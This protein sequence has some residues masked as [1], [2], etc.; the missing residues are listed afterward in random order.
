MNDKSKVNWPGNGMPPT[1]RWDDD[2]AGG[3]LARLIPTL[4]PVPTHFEEWIG[5]R[6]QERTAVL[7]WDI[8]FCEAVVEDQYDAF[9]ANAQPWQA[10]V[11][12]PCVS[13]ILR[14]FCLGGGSVAADHCLILDRSARRFYVADIE[15]GIRLLGAGYERRTMP[16][17]LERVLSTLAKGKAFRLA[18]WCKERCTV[19]TASK[20]S[21]EREQS[22]CEENK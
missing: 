6:G 9:T 1:I 12:S 16:S 18:S 5:Y 22:I 15:L 17:E 8:L 7:Y 21:L 19:P 14:P 10:F 11:S 20:T 4:I 13:E 3:D 2:A